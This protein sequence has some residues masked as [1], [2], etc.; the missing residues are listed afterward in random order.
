MIEYITNNRYGSLIY[1]IDGIIQHDRTSF[2]EIK[3]LCLESFFS[4]DGYL[5]AVKKQ[6][7]ISYKIPIYIH[8]ALQFIQTKRVRD[9]DNI[10]F[11]YAAV[12]NVKDLNK[13][14]EIEF[15]SGNKLLINIS[16]HT[17]K[18][19]IL[20]LDQIRKRKVNIFITNNIE[21]V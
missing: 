13:S 12:I 4:Y 17:L 16:Y 10:W 5:K 6:F 14:I 18:T 1:T 3:R 8:D 11:N 20:Y 15:V 9:H 21:K 2:F 19:Q 7:Q